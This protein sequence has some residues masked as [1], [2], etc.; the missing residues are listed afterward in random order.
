[1][2]R[3]SEP[4]QMVQDELRWEP[5]IT[6][7]EIG[8]SITDG[9]ATLTGQG[10]RYAEKRAAEWAAWSTPGVV[11]VENELVEEEVPTAS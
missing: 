3:A 8:V 2:R 5:S 6:A 9:V 10:D 1:M 7:A 4:Q 11:N